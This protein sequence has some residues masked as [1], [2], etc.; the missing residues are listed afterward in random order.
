MLGLNA[1]LLLGAKV[2]NEFV[3]D[4][5]LDS[6]NRFYGT[7]FALYGV[8]FILCSGDLDKYATV[9]RC[10]LW[11]FFAGGVARLVSIGI[12][13]MP[14]TTVVALLASEMLLPPLMLWWL[15]HSRA[16]K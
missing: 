13:G 7:C 8:L 14:S 2:P 4:P 6:Q 3:R 11:C 1:D 15:N 5:V 10:T 9:L 12:H 16:A